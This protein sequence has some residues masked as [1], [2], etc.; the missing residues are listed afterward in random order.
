MDYAA[1]AGGPGFAASAAVVFNVLE[2]SSRDNQK[3]NCKMVGKIRQTQEVSCQE[4]SGCVRSDRSKNW[5][6]TAFHG[7]VHQGTVGWRC[8]L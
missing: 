8:C 4:V 6:F 2:E 7:R 1:L 5:T 3:S